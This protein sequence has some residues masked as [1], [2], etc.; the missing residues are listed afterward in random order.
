MTTKTQEIFRCIVD[1]HVSEEAPT[2]LITKEEI[3]EDLRM[4]AAISD[5]HPVK[6]LVLVRKKFFCFNIKHNSSF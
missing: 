5:F 6:Q 1:E 3:I 4:R 2:K